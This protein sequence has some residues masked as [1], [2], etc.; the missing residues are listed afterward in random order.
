[1]KD[2]TRHPTKDPRGASARVL[3]DFYQTK[4]CQFSENYQELCTNIV[5]VLM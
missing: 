5:L 2:L 3:L 4:T 1:M